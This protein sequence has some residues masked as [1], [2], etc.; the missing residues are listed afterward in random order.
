MKNIFISVILITVISFFIYFSSTKNEDLAKV[1]ISQTVNHNALDRTVD[2]ILDGLKQENYTEEKNIQLKIESAKGNQTLGIQIANNFISKSPNVVVGVGTL[3]AQTLAGFSIKNNIPLVFSSITDPK[4]SGLVQENIFE[5][6]TK[7]DSKNNINSINH[8]KNITGVSNFIDL[9]EQVKLFQQ[10]QPG[11]KRLGILYNPGEANSVIIV[12]NLKKVCDDLNIKLTALAINNIS[13]ITQ[14]T[15]KLLTNN[16][17]IFISN[18][19][20]ALSA[21]SNIIEM[22]KKKKIPVYVSDTDAVELGALAAL[23]PNQ[24]D[25]GIQTGKMIAKILQGENI[26]NLSVEFPKNKELYLNMKIA[27]IMKIQFDESLIKQA[28]KIIK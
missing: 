22:S 16:D 9:E 1:Y 4:E 14:G 6:Q 20:T 5:I 7:N 19:N 23:G 18:D 17:A 26:E 28:S 27:E 21:L 8:R 2:G 3:S 13:Q 12:K 24:Y 11:L 15:A 10:I 25:I